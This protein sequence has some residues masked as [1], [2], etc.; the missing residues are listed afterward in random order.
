MVNF[1]IA[2]VNEMKKIVW[3]EKFLIDNGVID[4][5]HRNLVRII[6]KF[7]QFDSDKFIVKNI[8]ETLADLKLYTIDH[9]E[10]EEEIQ[11]KIGYPMSGAHANQHHSMVR[12]L[13]NIIEEFRM[14]VNM[15]GLNYDEI[16]NKIFSLLKTWLIQHIMVADT[17]LKP[18]L[19]PHLPRGSGTE[20]KSAR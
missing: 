12:Q 9:F 6:N 3:N 1:F 8:K 16:R 18:Y 17:S 14:T 10:R 19:D 4:E 20:G 7:C 2:S 5:D 15:R 11:K 13:D